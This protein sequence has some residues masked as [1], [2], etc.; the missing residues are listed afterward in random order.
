MH[1]RHNAADLKSDLKSAKRESKAYSGQRAPR[2]KRQKLEGVSKTL[3]CFSHGDF[4]GFL[5]E[6]PAFSILRL[7]KQSRKG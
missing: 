1:S 2:E 3:R 6:A 5:Y 7:R 4:R